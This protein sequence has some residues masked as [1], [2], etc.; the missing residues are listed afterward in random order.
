[1]TR[2]SIFCLFIF[3]T[4]MFPCFKLQVSERRRVSRVQGDSATPTTWSQRQFDPPSNKDMPAHSPSL[5]RVLYRIA[6]WPCGMLP[7]TPSINNI[8]SHFLNQG[9]YGACLL[10]GGHMVWSIIQ[11][12]SGCHRPLGGTGQ[13]NLSFTT[14][15]RTHR[16]SLSWTGPYWND[17]SSDLDA[18]SG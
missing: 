9:R 5:E 11:F 3:T 14:Q 4:L 2:W 7:P 12:L 1:M 16:F 17:T 18:P 6:C 10:N 15:D 8:S 13:W